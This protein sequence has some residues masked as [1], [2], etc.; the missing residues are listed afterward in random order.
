MKVE[1]T[2]PTSGSKT[3][4]ELPNIDKE[5]IEYFN[6]TDANDSQIKRFI[7]NLNV[8][9]DIKSILIKVAQLSFKTGQFI[10]K[11]G[12]RI[13]DCILRIL[14]EFPNIAFGLILGG[15]F[16]LLV[17]SIPFIGALI[18]PLFTSLAMLTGFVFGAKQDFANK[19]LKNTIDHALAGFSRFAE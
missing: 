11:I 1:A 18:A 12:R 2:N 15:V 8:S 3:V 4:K 17:T 9:A 6:N 13:F 14:K 19:Q 16:G 5:F 10:I 7:E